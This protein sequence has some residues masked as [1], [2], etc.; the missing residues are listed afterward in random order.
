MEE[1]L[2]RKAMAFLVRPQKVVDPEIPIQK[3]LENFQNTN[4]DALMILGIQNYYAV[5]KSSMRYR[6]TPKTLA[7]YEVRA[8]IP[9]TDDMFKQAEM[10]T[11]VMPSKALPFLQFKFDEYTDNRGMRQSWVE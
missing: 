6:L 7:F 3:L 2:P 4:K 5:F 9:L 11:Y 1:I 8:Y 10:I